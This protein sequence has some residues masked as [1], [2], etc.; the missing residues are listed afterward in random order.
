MRSF[1]FCI[2]TLSYFDKVISFFQI[3]S[4]DLNRFKQDLS[5]GLFV[6]KSPVLQTDNTHFVPR[7]KNFMCFN[8]FLKF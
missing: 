7:P 4:I 8:K 5:H 2:E 1:F 3:A 6:A